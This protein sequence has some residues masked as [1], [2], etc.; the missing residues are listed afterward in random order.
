METIAQAKERAN[1]YATAITQEIESD[2]AGYQF[3]GITCYTYTD[4]ANL[5]YFDE[6]SDEAYECATEFARLVDS[7]TDRDDEHALSVYAA[8]RS[9]TRVTYSPP[10]FAVCYPTA[11]PYA[12]AKFYWHDSQELRYRAS[13]VFDRMAA[14][15]EAGELGS[16]LENL[17]EVRDSAMRFRANQMAAA[18][19]AYCEPPSTRELADPELF[20]GW[21]IRWMGE[22]VL[23][24]AE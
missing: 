23:E 5:G 3:A 8:K 1:A 17:R 13:R 12:P 7:T 6:V 16:A 19:R 15:L 24:A 11:E 2:R 10:L 22:E 14:E 9:E 18:E 20:C 4:E 21:V